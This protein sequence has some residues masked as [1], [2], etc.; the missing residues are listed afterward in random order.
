M[1]KYFVHA[2][3]EHLYVGWKSFKMY[4]TWQKGPSLSCSFF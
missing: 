2:N 4:H 1:N 3:I